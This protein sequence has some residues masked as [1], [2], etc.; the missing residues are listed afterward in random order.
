MALLEGHLDAASLSLREEEEGI[1]RAAAAA[2]EGE[3]GRKGGCYDVSAWRDH[4]IDI[5]VCVCVSVY[6]YSH[7]RPIHSS[8]RSRTT[9]TTK[10]T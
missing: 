4:S 5:V 6:P 3:G 8:I 10:T 9:R 1:Y 2:G 7:H